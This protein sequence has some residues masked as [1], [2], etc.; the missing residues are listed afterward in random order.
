[1]TL[2][3]GS[4]I[5]KYTGV[6]IYFKVYIKIEISAESYVYNIYDRL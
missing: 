5:Y 6:F 1:M 3:L 2:F 4:I